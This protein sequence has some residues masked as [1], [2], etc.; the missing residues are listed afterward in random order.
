MATLCQQPVA[1]PRPRPRPHSPASRPCASSIAPATATAATMQQQKLIIRGVTTSTAVR[2]VLG[3]ED[4]AVL[5]D[6]PHPVTGV[7]LRDCIR[8]I[9]AKDRWAMIAPL[10]LS[11]P[12]STA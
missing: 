3:D 1:G 7:S 10:R 6:R 11:P 4:M 2:P 5:Y 9:V 12:R 8:S